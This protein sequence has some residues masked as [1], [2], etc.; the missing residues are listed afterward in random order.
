MQHYSTVLICTILGLAWGHTTALHNWR[1]ELGIGK[2]SHHS[3]HIIRRTSFGMLWTMAHGVY[4]E[5]L[6]YHH[7]LTFSVDEASTN[8]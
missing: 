6:V 5:D 2:L 4:N 7:T 1:I 3:A 8:W